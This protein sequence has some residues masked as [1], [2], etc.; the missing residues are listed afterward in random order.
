[1]SESKTIRMNHP[2]KKRP[3]SLEWA[4]PFI[5]IIANEMPA[6]SLPMLNTHFQRLDQIVKKWRLREFAR[7]EKWRGLLDWQKFAT[8]LVIVHL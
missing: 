6:L 5:V 3:P 1:M 8:R 2:A 7:C 4:T